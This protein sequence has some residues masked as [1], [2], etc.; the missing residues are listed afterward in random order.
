MTYPA[1]LQTHTDHPYTCLEMGEGQTRARLTD[2]RLGTIQTRRHMSGD[3]APKWRGSLKK[4]NHTLSWIQVRGK[5]SRAT[6]TGA[7]SIPAP[8]HAAG[9][10]AG[11]SYR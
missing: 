3:D 11:L 5:G 6:I 1:P 4:A 2:Q 7:G 9:L 8:V 10:R